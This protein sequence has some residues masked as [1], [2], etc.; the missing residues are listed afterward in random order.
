MQ[1]K[2]RPE[3]AGLHVTRR[4]GERIEVTCTCGCDRS[5]MIQVADIARRGGSVRLAFG[6]GMR[7]ERLPVAGGVE[8]R[9]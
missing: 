2:A 7:V 3:S 6:Q 8:C 1:V 9:D 4:L 5:L